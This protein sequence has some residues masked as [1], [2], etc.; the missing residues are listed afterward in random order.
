MK[1]ILLG[2]GVFAAILMLAA[3]G[4]YVYLNSQKII[5]SSDIPPANLSQED[6]VNL[7]KPGVVRIVHHISGDVSFDSFDFDL[8]TGDIFDD[9]GLPLK[10]NV[11]DDLLGT[12][13]V[14]SPDG[15]ILSNAHVVS[16]NADLVTKAQSLAYLVLAEKFS[17]FS[18]AQLESFGYTQDNAGAKGLEIYQNLLK[19]ILAHNTANLKNELTVLNP[20]SIKNTLSDSVKD[21]SVA[22]LVS[23]NSNF[24]FDGKDVGEIKIDPKGKLPVIKLGNSAGLNAGNKIYI[25][26]FPASADANGTNLSE[27]TFT[28]GSIGA[29][30]DSVNKDFQLIQ[31][32]A[33]ISPG[34]SGGPL[35]NASGEA[36]GVVTYESDTSTNSQGDNFAFAIP[37]QIPKDFLQA[38]NLL[39]GNSDYFDHIVRG[40]ALMQASHCRSAISEFD[41]AKD[42]I[43]PDFS[44]VKYIDPYVADC[45]QMIAAKKSIDTKFDQLAASIKGHGKTTAV[46]IIVFII[47]IFA[48]IVIFV[49]YKRLNRDEKRF[50]Q[51]NDQK[52]NPPPPISPAQLIA[53]QPTA[54]PDA[55]AIPGEKTGL[56]GK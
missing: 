7:V 10:V 12:G 53:E 2:L 38:S 33:K 19:Y 18:D 28:Q 23:A 15:Y 16:D 52:I 37:I 39:N 9:H 17:Q 47:I 40:L 36:I 1:K 35:F 13:F 3:A 50:E 48:S 29:F 26:G 46:A 45:Q 24:E 20:S 54:K 21:G 8:K 11:D 56:T 32:D 27:S 55:N 22:T 43:N 30:K 14:V 41:Q 4:V 44:L 34:S 6:L 42:N 5:Y 25:F 31:T 49:L 51:L